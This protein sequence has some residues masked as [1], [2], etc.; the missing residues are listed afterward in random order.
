VESVSYFGQWHRERLKLLGIEILGL[1]FS[2][3]RKK[4][5]KFPIS[6]KHFKKD[7]I[8][9]KITKYSKTFLAL[10]RHKNKLIFDSL[11]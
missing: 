6:A 9:N 10:S 8:F 11:N 3:A 5:R 7:S 4:C 2:I 1:T